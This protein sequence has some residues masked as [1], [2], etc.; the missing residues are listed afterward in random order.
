MEFLLNP[1]NALTR[2]CRRNKIHFL[3]IRGRDV[4]ATTSTKFLDIK[5]EF[6]GS[7]SDLIETN[8]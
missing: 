3:Y 2:K 8:Y 7:D 5:Y 6:Y 1:G 4:K